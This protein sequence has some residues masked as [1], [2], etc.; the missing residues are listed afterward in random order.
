MPMLVK[1]KATVLRLGVFG[2]G[3]DPTVSPVGIHHR[4]R[5]EQGAN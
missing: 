2:S 5:P 4:G 3:R 1:V